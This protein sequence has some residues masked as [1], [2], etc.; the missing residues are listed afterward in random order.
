MA[1]T[2]KTKLRWGHPDSYATFAVR[3]YVRGGA[4]HKAHR[5]EFTDFSTQGSVWLRPIGKG[6]LHFEIA[7]EYVLYDSEWSDVPQWNPRT[8][9]F[10]NTIRIE[11]YKGSF[12]YP[13]WIEYDFENGDKDPYT[14]DFRDLHISDDVHVGK[15]D[16]NGSRQFRLVGRP[17]LDTRFG[18]HTA[19][20][21]YV[22]LTPAFQL[23]TESRTTTRQTN[24]DVGVEH[25]G[26]GIGVSH[27]TG[28]ER[29]HNPPQ[30]DEPP[31]GFFRLNLDVF[32]IP[33]AEI[34]QPQHVSIVPNPLVLLTVIPFDYDRREL[35]DATKLIASTWKQQ[36]FQTYPALRQ[37]IRDTEV[38]VYFDGYASIPGK[39]GYN[40]QIGKD[41]A[42]AVIKYLGSSAA[43]TSPTASPM[44]R[45][46]WT[47]RCRSRSRLPRLWKQHTS[48][49]S[50]IAI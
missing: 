12:R 15:P 19:Y 26:V 43:R 23:P 33:L 21:P 32:K 31:W 38:R 11:K 10:D 49:G 42:E 40:Y 45:F 44:D 16:E 46:R 47:R 36:L 30:G 35:T 7:A 39:P 5:H 13:Y 50:S 18:A 48:G 9:K 29:Q 17:T 14:L 34:K 6:T 2:F 22:K 1:T 41:R 20:P 27:S 25:E 28:S 24:I 37:A 3:A 8:N 4:V